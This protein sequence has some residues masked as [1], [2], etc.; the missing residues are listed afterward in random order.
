MQC[1][2]GAVGIVADMLSRRAAAE[3]P[4]LSTTLTKTFMLVRRSMDYPS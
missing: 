2:G 1:A 4:P 3:K